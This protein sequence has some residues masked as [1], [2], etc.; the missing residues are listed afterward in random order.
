MW[1]KK[2]V[3]IIGYHEFDK[4]VKTHLDIDYSIIEDE[5]L[6]NYSLYNLGTL[7]RKGW[8][9]FNEIRLSKDK[10]IVEG[11]TYIHISPILAHE[12]VRRGIIPPGIWLVEVYIGKEVS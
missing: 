9:E 3:H 8:D 5:W 4:L 11:K 7:P 2:E 6:H 10:W 1:E 12:L